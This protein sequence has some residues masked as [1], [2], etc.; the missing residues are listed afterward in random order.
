MIGCQMAMSSRGVMQRLEMCVDRRDLPAHSRGRR[1]ITIVGNN[2]IVD[3]I[4]RARCALAPHFPADNAYSMGKKTPSRRYAMR[5]IVN[6]SEED[7][8][9]DTDNMHKKW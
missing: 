8:A 3:S 1:K 5:P 7:G 6:M 4:L 2:A 9:T